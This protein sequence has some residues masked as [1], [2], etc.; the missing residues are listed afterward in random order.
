MV[1]WIAWAVPGDSQPGSRAVGGP[2]GA[3]EAGL[4][5]LSNISRTLPKPRPGV[6]SNLL[7][8]A[9]RT[10]ASASPVAASPPLSGPDLRRPKHPDGAAVSLPAATQVPMPG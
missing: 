10:A 8:A 1:V 2:D 7:S 4:A 5:G 6:Q 3:E 9:S